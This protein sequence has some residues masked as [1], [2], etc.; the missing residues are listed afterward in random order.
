PGRT[1][2]R[3]GECRPGASRTARARRDRPGARHARAGTGQR[4]S[5]PRGGRPRRRAGGTGAGMTLS[6]VDGAGRAR[7][8]DVGDK[9]VTS[10]IAVAEGA[11]RLSREAHGLVAAN[12]L[13]KGDVLATAELA[14]LMAAKRTSELV[15]LCHQVPLDRVEVVAVLSDEEP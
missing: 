2:C 12:A 15:P 9:S 14:G 10:R 7:M 4:E 6:H 1:A 5:A 13:R 8:V 11:V 3:R